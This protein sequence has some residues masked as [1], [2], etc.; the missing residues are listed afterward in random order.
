MFCQVNRVVDQS[1]RDRRVEGTVIHE[2]ERMVVEVYDDTRTESLYV[3]VF[4]ET[5]NM[6]HTVDNQPRIYTTGRGR[7]LAVSSDPPELPTADRKL[8]AF[9]RYVLQAPTAELDYQGP[10]EPSN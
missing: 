5:G 8:E 4:R 2:D 6:T 9:I 1:S 10:D 7:V 3:K